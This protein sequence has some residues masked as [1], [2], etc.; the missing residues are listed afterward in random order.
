MPDSAPGS[1]PTPRMAPLAAEVARLGLTLT[2]EQ[3]EAFERYLDLTLERNE[4]AGITSISDEAEIQR[5]HFAESLALLVALRSAGLVPGTPIRVADLGTGGGFPGLPMR[6]AD[7]S[8]RL[9]LI[10]SHGRRCDFLREVVAALGLEGVEVVQARAE[11]AGRD[12]ALRAAFDLVVARAL[13]AVR[14]LTEY[15]VPLLR[16]SGV[17]AT[18]KGSRWQDE[19]TEAGQ[20]LAEL[21]SVALNAVPMPLE[22]GAPEQTVVLIQR[23]GDLSDRYPR[24]AGIPTKRPL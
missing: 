24:R 13:A 9:T 5:R 22:P 8:L 16:D 7:P 1:P 17:L 11:D 15:G 23:R 20:A 2:P 12:P 3:S 19:L 6:I 14:V 4:W 21:S 18:P 10:E